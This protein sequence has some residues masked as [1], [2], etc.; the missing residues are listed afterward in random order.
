MKRIFNH[1]IKYP[2]LPTAWLMLLMVSTWMSYGSAWADWRT[3]VMTDYVKVPVFASYAAK[4]NIMIMLDNSGSMNTL[5]YSD[6]YTG[7]PYN[8]T[9]KSFP[10][11]LE[12]DDMEENPSGVLRDAAGSGNDL[13]FGS[14]LVGIRFQDVDLP[15][16]A[17]ITSARI[18]FTSKN[19]WTGIVTNLEIRG[20]AS[21][22]AAFLDVADNFNISNRTVTAASVSWTPGDWVSGDQYDTP[23]LTGIVQEIVDR[24]D[25]A[26]DNA[27]LFR[28][29]SPGFPAT[30]SG[31]REA[32]SR[33]AGQNVAPVLHVTYIDQAAGTRYYGYFNPDY[34]YKHS[35]NV[36]WPTYKKVKY[37]PA[38]NS[39]QVKS[40][41]G[42]TSTLTD[43]DI[44]PAVPADGLWDGNWMNW[45]SMRRVDVLRKVLMGGKATSRTGGGN[46]QNQA[47]SAANGWGQYHYFNSTNGPATSPYKGGYW[48]L[49]EEDGEISIYGLSD[50]P[51]KI[52]I[53]KDISIEPQDFFEG[54]LAGVLQRIGDRARWGNMWFN[55][56]TGSNNSGGFV[57]NPIDNG[58]GVNFLPDLQ[59]QKCNTWTPLAETFYVAS[60][61]FAQEAVA[62]GLDFPNQAQLFGIGKD[63]LKDPYW[64]KDAAISVPC[65]KSFVLL[66]TDGAST[67]DSKIPSGLKDFDKDGTEKTSC[68]EQT[69]SNCDYSSYGTDYLD[70]VA[71]Y[72]RT[73]DLR[74]DLDDIQNIL[75]YTVFAF[76]DNPNAR[77]LLQDAARNGGFEDLDGDNLPNL[78]AEWDKDND[79]IP[80]TYYEA[81]DGYSLER[82]LL[83]A[84]NAILKRA[85][86]G[87]AASV[88]SNSR[89]GEG[90]VYQSIFYPAT[91]GGANTVKWVGQV[92]SLLSDAH[93]NLREDTNGNKKLDLADDLFIVFG[94][95]TLEKYKDSDAD[96]IFDD[97]DAGPLTINNLSEFTL[98]DIN[99]LWSS[100]D[101]LNELTDA[102]NQ[103]SYESTAQQRYIFTFVDADGDMVPD[104]GEVKDFT[105]TVDPSWSQVV[106][107]A[108]Y[109][110]YIHAFNTPFASPPPIDTAHADF[111]DVVIRQIRRTINFTRGQDQPYEV[112]GSTPLSAFRNRL[113]DYDDDGD[114]ETWRL[115]DIVY[116]TPTVVGQ[117]A[118]DFD[119]IYKDKGYS[120]F[121]RRYINRRNVIYVGSND[122]MIHAFNSG[123]FD[124]E[125]NGFVTKPVDNQG[126]DI[127]E[128]GPYREFD[129]G[130]EL[131]AYVPFN[132][133]SHLHWMTAPEY[134]HIY[135]NDLQPRIFDA[136][137]YPDKG[138]NDPTNPNGWATI[139][140]CGMRFGGGKIAA[141]IDKKDGVYNS[142]VD[143]TMS[144]AYVIFD[145]TN[146]EDPPIL[147]GEITFPELG[148][149]TCHPGVIPMRDFDVNNLETTNQ[150]YLIFGSGPI[151]ADGASTDAL[152]NGTSTQQAVMYA[153]DLVELATNK[154]LVTLTG[155]GKKEFTAAA[156]ADPYY[157]VQ[158]SENDSFVSKPIA[159]DWDLDFNTDAAYFGTTSGS[160]AGGW[161]GKLR[162]LVMDNGADPTAHTNWTLDSTLLDL[163][164]GVSKNLVNGQPITASATAGTDKADDRW[165]YFGTGRFY[166]Q[167]DK[168][169]VDQQ[170]YYGV[171][172]PYTIVDS[173]KEFNYNEVDFD[174]LMDVTNIK[175]YE[176]GTSLSGFSGDFQDLAN[177]IE[178]NE[179][180]W[181]LEFDYKSGD[182]NLG[183]AVLAGDVLTFTTYVPSDDP[184]SIAGES[185]VYALYY[186][187]GTAY[188][189]SI[190]GLDTFD[191]VGDDSLV[192]KRT[193]LGMG[194]TITPNIHVGRESGSQAYIQTS[195]GSIKPID[196]ENP[197]VVKSGRAPVQPGDQT[198]P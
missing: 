181:R 96:G 189:S 9:T 147:L 91:T 97:T 110:A 80:D 16:G 35:S 191:T 68:N 130:S 41:A 127:T 195:T 165:L 93:G 78:Q 123:F 52:D 29:S 58:F 74:A 4:P 54:N 151:A 66:L 76:D 37:D 100:N 51:Y 36:F 25:W 161:N 82:E 42:A 159:V 32:Y 47:E 45:L 142:A 87:T 173:K 143:K 98:S 81:S 104:S 59:N 188:T 38:T 83:A 86:S 89:S 171:K 95:D 69:N 22:D 134:E 158:F 117:P 114:V 77:S 168:M 177:H 14:D 6:G 197:G 12:R 111:E 21:D 49:I 75:L 8:G 55:G 44:A 132:L 194:M 146:P 72:A 121:Y 24:N 15:Q 23:D 5:A 136:R 198:C 170:S 30:T 67:M 124:K 101:W 103:R 28:I 128:G 90:A 192:L 157:L 126:N 33:E 172:E 50:G 17:T 65:A 102:V 183:E 185:Q 84:I 138:P 135:F 118:E 119:L 115:G 113:I 56:G 140:V 107:P 92:H 122:G 64:D 13:D 186:R 26:A 1:T 34:F 149:T 190:I 131:W 61:Y 48:Y 3:P 180:G 120:E 31:H 137:V 148:F 20:E 141:D 164:D 133:L 176:N 154:K 63:S 196:E 10:V 71:L 94:D 129:I 99:Y 125:N 182:R 18:E 150:W 144:S 79:N 7:V 46:Q 156:A 19:N 27:M 112:V 53:Q 152:L 184:C 109:Y 145:I 163:T 105:A 175:V 179:Q 39:W 62:S 166:S 40:I 167:D 2:V 70:D 60:Q 169:N 178:D 116:S 139:M 108:N 43:A 11:V 73:T 57:Q 187:T 160:P 174:D 106:D 85:S 88:V 155:A 153:I 193:E 162:R